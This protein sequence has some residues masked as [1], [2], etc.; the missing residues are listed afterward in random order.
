[1]KILLERGA[2]ANSFDSTN[3][4]ALS[5]VS[6]INSGIA[7]EERKELIQL[8]LDY[9]ADINAKDLNGETALDYA[10]HDI[11]GFLVSLGAKKG[12]GR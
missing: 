1:M 10:C 8:L 3:R 4:S 7:I 6:Y 2:D 12:D 11:K 9:G 5:E